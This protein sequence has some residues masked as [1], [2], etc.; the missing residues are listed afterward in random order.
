MYLTLPPA[1]QG[2]RAACC[3]TRPS[4]PH[5]QSCPGSCS[6]LR[7]LGRI[8][9]VWLAG[10]LGPVLVWPGRSSLICKAWPGSEKGT[11]VGLTLG[12]ASGNSPGGGCPSL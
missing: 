10:M 3:R 4:Y 11:R 1:T 12:R 5:N 6:F 2:H 8:V 7:S 9:P